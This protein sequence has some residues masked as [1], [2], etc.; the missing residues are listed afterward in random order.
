MREESTS[1]STSSGDGV[2][3][4]TPSVAELAAL[5]HTSNA[6]LG[7]ADFEGRMLWVNRAFLRSLGYSYD[8]VRS[9]SYL[10][11]VHPDDRPRALAAMADL[12][13]GDH[14][15][16]EL[17]V[18]HHDGSWLVLSARSAVDSDRA[19]IFFSAVDLTTQK[20]QEES[21]REA[22]EQLELFNM[23]VA[24]D[25]R[26]PLTILDLAIKTYFRGTGEES[27]SHAALAAHAAKSVRRMTSLLDSLLLLA[28]ARAKQFEPVDLYDIARRTAESIGALV[29]P[30]DELK[31]TWDDDLPQVACDGELVESVIEN[32]VLNAVR[33][34]RARGSRVHLSARQDPAGWVIAVDDTGPGVPEADRDWIFEPGRRGTDAGPMGHGLGLTICRRLVASWGGRIWVEDAPGGTGSRFAFTLPM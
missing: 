1:A 23:A 33:H 25:L 4:F 18:Q 32:L 14:V 3:P 34:S 6:V 20:Q 2:R 29:D 28:S 13:S 12:A 9:I 11:M 19:R 21:L 16:L 15:S 24:H 8:E 22:N 31:L 5:V 7:I 27:A 30:A 17:R 26:N 10:D